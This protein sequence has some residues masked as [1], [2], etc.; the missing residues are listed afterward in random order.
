MPVPAR[1]DTALFNSLGKLASPNGRPFTAAVSSFVSKYWLALCASESPKQTRSVCQAPSGRAAHSSDT[2][3]GSSTSL[4]LVRGSKQPSADIP[5]I[6]SSL[7]HLLRE[8]TYIRHV[9]QPMLG[10]RQPPRAT[11]RAGGDR[12][13]GGL[14]CQIPLPLPFTQRDF[15]QSL[16]NGVLGD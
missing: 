2:L 6:P 7:H 16:D 12:E 10:R 15:D 4:R 9:R 13:H 14:T 3:S 8:V 5:D 11:R 1:K